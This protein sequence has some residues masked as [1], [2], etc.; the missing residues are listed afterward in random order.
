MIPIQAT[1]IRR[2]L[3]LGVAASAETSKPLYSTETQ[4]AISETTA[5]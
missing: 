2:N 4:G 3:Q 1:K 5:I